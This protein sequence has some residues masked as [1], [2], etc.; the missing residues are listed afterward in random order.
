MTAAI[1]AQVA[2]W[3]QIP[4][5]H[6]Q[7]GVASD[8]LLCP[9]PQEANR[10]IIGQ[11]ASL[12]LTTGGAAHGQPDRA[13]RD[14]GRRHDGGQPAARRPALRPPGP[15]GARRAARGWCWSGSTGPTRSACSPACPTCSS[16][17][18]TSR[19]CCTASSPRTAPPTRCCST[20]R[21]TVVPQPAAGRA[22]RADRGERRAGLRRPRAGHR[23]ARASARPA[24]LVD[25][26]H[27]PEPG[28]SIRSILSPAVMTT[29]R[30]V[31]AAT[32]AARRS[33]RPTGW[34]PR[35]SSRRWRG[36]SGSARRRC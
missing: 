33:S 14:P 20:T 36:C 13:Q 12:F 8:D 6:L 3:R 22:G 5:V 27:I 31:L 16:A 9:F 18:R 11:L 25:G 10:R 4:V 29:V 35:A 23:R 28:D 32:A 30:Q 1:A 34:R 19:S 26:P 24:V 15:P 21:A 7:A 17:S 2:F